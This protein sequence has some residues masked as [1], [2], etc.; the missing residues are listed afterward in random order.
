MNTATITQA[1]SK[2][3]RH[4]FADVVAK[5]RGFAIEMYT[6]HGGWFVVDA[7]QPASGALARQKQTRSMILGASYENYGPALAADLNRIDSKE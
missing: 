7:A 3:L 1:Q 2:G 6:A 5:V 4:H